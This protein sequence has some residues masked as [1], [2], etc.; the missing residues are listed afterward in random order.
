MESTTKNDSNGQSEPPDITPQSEPPNITPQP[1]PPDIT[2]QYEP[3]DITPQPEPP[4][5][6]HQS[7]PPDITPQSEPPDIT[8]QPEPPDITSQ[9]KPPDITPQP[10]PPDITP[11]S[12][13]PDITPQSEPS[14]ITPGLISLNLS[15][16]HTLDLHMTEEAKQEILQSIEDEHHIVL[17]VQLNIL[18]LLQTKIPRERNKARETLE[19]IVQECPNHLNALAD[20]EHIYRELHRMS[21]AERC[22]K[23]ITD[24]LKGGNPDDMN[25]RFISLLE[26]AYA[27]RTERT[28]IN[29]NI[30]HLRVTDLQKLI[31]REFKHSNGAKRKC[32]GR[33][34]NCSK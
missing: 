31:F 6:T 29:E 30:V 17:H 1:E 19:E 26:Q 34:L 13:P 4:D 21:D 15:I 3:P 27:I 11:Q 7:E 24:V 10:E 32:L 25:S 23:T 16:S 12:E 20:L 22:R 2:P 9:S 8:P 18:A 33:T 5:I 14:D 28:L